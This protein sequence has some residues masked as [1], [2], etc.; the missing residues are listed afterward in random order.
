MGRLQTL[1]GP[2][3]SAI[4]PTDVGVQSYG[5]RI[6]VTLSAGSNSCNWVMR[7]DGGL[8]ESQRGGL[9][10]P[11]AAIDWLFKQFLLGAEVLI[12]PK[13]GPRSHGGS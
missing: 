13:F 4:S 11:L 2:L 8:S 12:G 10:L 7:T 3:S 5:D 9:L 1:N 6:R